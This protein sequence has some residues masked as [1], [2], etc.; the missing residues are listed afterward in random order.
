MGLSRVYRAS[1][2][3]ASP[4]VHVAVCCVFVSWMAPTTRRQLQGKDTNG[5]EYGDVDEMW[6]R[7]AGSKRQ[8][9]DWYSKGT[10]VTHG[11]EP[12]CAGYHLPPL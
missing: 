2:S 4:R 7:E 6:A 9:E 12:L 3:Q 1:E 10:C 11:P 5:T 8:R